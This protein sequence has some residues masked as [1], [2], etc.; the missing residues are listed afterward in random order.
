MKGTVGPEPP[1]GLHTGTKTAESAR[2]KGNS[3]PVADWFAMT[4]FLT[5]HNN[6]YVLKWQ[7]VLT[8][9]G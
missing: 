5:S 7:G 4:V 3:E 6:N 9:R 1:E 2:L 8:C